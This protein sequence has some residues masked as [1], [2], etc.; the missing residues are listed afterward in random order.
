[1]TLCIF[2]GKGARKYLGDYVTVELPDKE[3]AL[4][5]ELSLWYQSV[6]H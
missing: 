2:L 4:V 1:M 5:P 3:E 6:F